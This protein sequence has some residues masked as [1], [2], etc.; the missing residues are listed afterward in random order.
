MISYWGKCVITYL[1]FNDSH[2]L[3]NCTSFDKMLG[4]NLHQKLYLNICSLAFFFCGHSVGDLNIS[5]I[6]IAFVI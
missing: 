5:F 6:G 2:V 3:L 1:I 4:H